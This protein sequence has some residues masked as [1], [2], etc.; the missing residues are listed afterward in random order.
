MDIWT[1][2]ESIGFV[3]PVHQL[4]YEPFSC[5]TV[6]QT[7]HATFSKYT[8]KNSQ[9]QKDSLSDHYQFLRVAGNIHFA[10]S[11]FHFHL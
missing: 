6:G 1:R 10:L 11:C 3:V 9:V 8:I 7:R 2:D 5:G 4:T